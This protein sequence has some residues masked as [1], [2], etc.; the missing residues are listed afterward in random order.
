M[1]RPA[2]GG[3]NADEARSLFEEHLRAI[4]LMVSDVILPGETGPDLVAALKRKKPE[5][6]VIYVSG[7][8]DDRIR[9]ESLVESGARLLRKP[10]ALRE[11]LETVE[12]ALADA[13]NP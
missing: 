5:L 12:G 10:V 3:K 1:R 9:P 13:R 6:P 8:T 2:I 11:L 7:Y 4:D